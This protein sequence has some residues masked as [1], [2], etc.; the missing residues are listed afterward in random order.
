MIN[1]V[2]SQVGTAYETSV[3]STYTTGWL[4]LVTS[5]YMFYM[6]NLPKTIK[7]IDVYYE[8]S[9]GT[10]NFNLQN[11]KGDS[12]ANF[13]IDMSQNPPIPQSYWGGISNTTPGMLSSYKMYR[14]L[15]GLNDNNTI[16]TSNPPSGDKFLLSLS[17][18]G[19]G[20]WRIQRIAIR[21]DLNSYRPY[22]NQ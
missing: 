5:P 11:L 1:L 16:S 3:P 19:T 7:E 17:E 20:N 14:W 22:A 12:V 4:D 21:Y 15:P 13:N 9:V 6:S 2:Y 18:S 10:M 8:G